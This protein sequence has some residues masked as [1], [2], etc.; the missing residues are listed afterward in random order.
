MINSVWPD[1]LFQKEDQLVIF[2]L[3]PV[4][5]KTLLVSFIF[6]NATDYFS[7]ECFDQ[8]KIKF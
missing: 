4:Q 1:R 2:E 3:G 8:I 6:Q 5:I 7:K